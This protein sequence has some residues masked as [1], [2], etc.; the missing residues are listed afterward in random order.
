MSIR[1]SVDSLCKDDMDMTKVPYIYK[2]LAI[3]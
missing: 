2:N 1:E 3:S